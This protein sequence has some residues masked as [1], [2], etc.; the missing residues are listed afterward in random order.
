M[1]MFD[2]KIGSLFPGWQLKREK[3]RLEL[4]AIGNLSPA[5]EGASKKKRG[6]K[7]W[8]TN[9]L[10]PSA[11]Q[12]G[13]LETLTARSRDLFRN[14]SLGRSAISTTKTNV[15][16]PGL[17]M[18]CAIDGGYLNLSD[19]DAEEWERQVEREF[20]LWCKADHCDAA[21]MQSF[22][23]I[24]GLAMLAALHSGDVFATLPY[25]PRA[26][27]PYSLRVQLIEGDRVCNAGYQ[28][29]SDKL[30]GGIKTD[31]FGAPVE[32]HVLTSHPG[33]LDFGSKQKWEKIP[34][35]GRASGRRNVLHL[36]AIDRPGQR[37]GL[38]FLTPVIE[39][40]HL[41]GKYSDA[42]LMGAL[43]SGMF[44]VFVKSERPPLGDFIENDT[45]NPPAPGEM[46]LGNGMIVDLLPGESIE[47]ASP[48]RP[49]A[50][51]EGFF[52]AITREV[53]AALEIPHEILIKH[54]TASY[55]ASRAAL[56]EAW[57]FFRT[58]RSWLVAQFCQPIYEAFLTELVVNRR[59]S[60]P[61]FLDDPLIK[62]AYCK[63]MWIG[64]S[65]GQINPVQE[66]KAAQMKIDYR[67]STRAAETAAMGGDFEANHRQIVKER[68]MADADGLNQA[69]ENFDIEENGKSDQEN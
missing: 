40:L 69:A 31:D 61:G 8:M 54:F 37:R 4:K 36:L 7:R 27:S 41:L 64:P 46:N 60:A 2:K 68:R 5:F 56:L 20:S 6:L 29:D 67:L 51:F 53:G 30:F 13:E 58:R 32:Y 11:E 42:E 66:T 19:E 52:T 28:P 3:A 62:A 47:T 23:E 22:E 18:K 35:F 39:H 21:R 16:G 45:E 10:S 65:Q 26:G 24:Q 59:V 14:N 48:G 17:V 55:S 12:S 38:P 44:T 57:K 9:L 63:A 25:I 50:N 43:V 33:G 15:V 1:T 34:A 49:N